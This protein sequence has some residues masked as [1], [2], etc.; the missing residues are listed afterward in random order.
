[1]HDQSVRFRGE[2]P[3]SGPGGVRLGRNLD[4][5][6]VEAKQQNVAILHDVVAA[7]TANQALLRG[8]F[9]AARFYKFRERDGLG[10]DEAALKIGMNLAGGVIRGFTP[11]HGPRP[12][13][14][15]ADREE[16]LKSQQAIARVNE[17]IESG[18][19][20]AGTRQILA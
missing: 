2:R 7:F 20:D 15:L 3:D 14:I 11:M 13:L 4:A 9:V 6:D 8:S 1:A 18:L 5:L 16:R 12:H 10:A 17:T 19:R